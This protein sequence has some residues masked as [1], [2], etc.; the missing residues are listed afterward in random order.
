MSAERRHKC[1]Q[2]AFCPWNS[3][4]NPFR[5][6]RKIQK[7]KFSSF[8]NFCHSF[9]PAQVNL[10]AEGCL[11]KWKN[12]PISTLRRQ[13]KQT[14]RNLKKRDL[15]TLLTGPFGGLEGGRGRGRSL[16]MMQ[17]SCFFF[18]WYEN[19][20]QSIRPHFKPRSE[21]LTVFTR[22][23]SRDC[24]PFCLWHHHHHQSIV[25]SSPVVVLDQQ[26]IIKG[27]IH[28]LSSTCPTE[29]QTS[30]DLWPLNGSVPRFSTDRK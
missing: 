21:S 9:D 25:Q 23:V 26:F 11:L 30:S 20:G 2:A 13:T 6:S 14:W 15:E 17:A 16:W 1:S 22:K 19:A 28:Q 27:R 12:H 3:A 10:C 4:E 8:L 24:P 5:R 29:V 7:I 18:S